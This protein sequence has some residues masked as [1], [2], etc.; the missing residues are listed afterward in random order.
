[1]VVTTAAA[2]CDVATLTIG[3][4]DGST[5]ATAAGVATALPAVLD[6][7]APQIPVPPTPLSAS[8]LNNPPKK[9]VIM[10][11][12]IPGRPASI[13]VFKFKPAPRANAKK[14]N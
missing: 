14:R 2:I 12:R 1:M 8:I 11:K 6:A 10:P 4:N 3:A 13:I 7:A 9:V 5:R